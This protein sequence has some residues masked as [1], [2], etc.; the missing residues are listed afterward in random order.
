MAEI[1]DFTAREV[2]EDLSATRNAGAGARKSL[3]QHF[4][5]DPGITARIAALAGT[6]AGRPVLEIGPGPGG[7]TAALLAAGADP[8][9]AIERDPRFAGALRARGHERLKVVEG[10]ALTAD[11][12]ALLA[13]HA[14]GAENVA[15][16]ANL[17]YNIATPLLVKWL[18]AAPWRG[19]MILMFQ[20]EVAD[21]ICAPPNSRAYGRLS[22]LAQSLSLPRMAMKLGPGA[23]SPPPKVASAVVSFAPLAS[24]ADAP[25][26]EML[27]KVTEAAF[28]QRR[29]ML[30]GALQGFARH[31]GIDAQAWLGAAGID[32][33]KRAEALAIADFHRL[34]LA[35]VAL[36]GENQ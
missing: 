4:L 30:R 7:L 9:I 6:I 27:E 21:R 32:P 29:K 11:E 36:G 13:L 1:P 8:L 34:T 35:L 20:K 2:L 5:L 19:P 23:F 17:P 10:D 31:R 25:N 22:V 16:I 18:K 33:E 3:G 28:G 26:V 15:I 12:P 24:G 14:P